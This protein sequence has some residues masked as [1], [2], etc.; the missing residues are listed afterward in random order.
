MYYSIHCKFNL[1]SNI[2]HVNQI[3]L[4][5]TYQ[6]SKAYLFICKREREREKK[7]EEIVFILNLCC[8]RLV[9]ITYNLLLTLTC[10]IIFQWW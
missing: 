1:F 10:V 9:R 7:K 2:Y 3:Y 5:M 6:L 8:M 4:N